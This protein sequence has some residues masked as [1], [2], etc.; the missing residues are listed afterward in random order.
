MPTKRSSTEQIVSKL[1]QAEVKLG[2]G[3]HVPRG[4]SRQVVAIRARVYFRCDDCLSSLLYTFCRLLVKPRHLNSWKD[5][6]KTLFRI[7]FND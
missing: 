5:I 2:R 4:V 6:S 7:M 1:R 3:L